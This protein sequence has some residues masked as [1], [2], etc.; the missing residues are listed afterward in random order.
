MEPAQ[1]GEQM[2]VVDVSAEYPQLVR[3]DTAEIDGRGVA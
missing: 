3:W 2:Q 1:L